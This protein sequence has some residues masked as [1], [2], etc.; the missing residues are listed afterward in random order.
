[1]SAAQ[2][3]ELVR[4][5]ETGTCGG[6]ASRTLEL[7]AVLYFFITKYTLRTR[8]APSLKA[9]GSIIEPCKQASVV[10]LRLDTF[11]E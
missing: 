1:M 5:A 8:A 2:E 6:C 3:R 4:E 10:N 9:K 11:S 7:G